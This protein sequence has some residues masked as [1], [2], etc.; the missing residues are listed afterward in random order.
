MEF[1]RGIEDPRSD[2]IYSSGNR[3]V[4]KGPGPRGTRDEE[5]LVP[6][7]V[8]IEVKICYQFR[9]EN[10]LASFMF[11]RIRNSITHL[12]LVS[13]KVIN[14]ANDRMTFISFEAAHLT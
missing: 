12:P 9:E 8:H 4:K 10:S 14:T 11:D 1:W 5:F 7:L 6:S 2:R 13:T 3:R